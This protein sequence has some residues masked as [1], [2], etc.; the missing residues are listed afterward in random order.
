VIV[1][2]QAAEANIVNLFAEG[3]DAQHYLPGYALSS[4]AAPAVLAL[5]APAAQLANMHGVGWLPSADTLNLQQ[6]PPTPTGRRCLDLMKKQGLQPT[7]NSDYVYIYGPCDSFGL[8]EA[9]LKATNGD[10][11]TNT[12]MRALAAVGKSYVSASTV[13]G[14]EATGASGRIYAGAAR[15][16]AF[17]SGKFQYT[18]DA[19]KL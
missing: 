8:Y 3:A 2:S 14:E 1:V 5:N 12:V 18:S 11:T 7:S 17:V 16:F 15:L 6:S 13:N 10:S 4:I 9:V 19:F